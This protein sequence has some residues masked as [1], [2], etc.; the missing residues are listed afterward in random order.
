[1]RRVSGFRGMC[2]WLATVMLLV[3]AT[4]A[5]ARRW[6]VGEVVKQVIPNVRPQLLRLANR[7]G[8]AV[9]ITATCVAAAAV[10]LI[11]FAAPTDAVAADYLSSD[12]ELVKT[13][14]AN[15][16]F[17]KEPKQ[18]KALDAAD[19]GLSF[20]HW[21]AKGVFHDSGSNVGTLRL[22]TSA[23]VGSFSAY[24][25]SAFRWHPDTINGTEDLGVSTRT[26][27][28]GNTLLFNNGEG[29]MSYGYLNT[30]AFVG[31]T[32][33]NILNARA[34][35]LRWHE[36]VFQIAALGYEYNDLYLNDLSNPDERGDPVRSHGAA[37]YRAGIKYPITDLFTTSDALAVNVKLNS[38]M[39]LGDIGPVKLGET[40]QAELNDWAGDGADLNHLLHHSAGGSINV[41]LADGRI[42]LTFGGGIQH[43][44]DGDIK[45]AGMAEGD[46]DIVNTTVSVGGTVQ[47]SERIKLEAWF[48]RYDQATEA[49]LGGQSYEHNASGTWG[50]FAGVWTY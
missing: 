5:E 26:Y 48:D 39:H 12:A 21:G 18:L 37:I 41:S 35:L 31:G 43:T 42:N 8:G 25:T 29:K 15:A 36:G 6:N 50:R 16:I 38:A 14:G 9:K 49:Y 11:N 17:A 30:D 46:F 34:H 40:W 22:G 1:M 2:L 20:S 28:G 4:S 45:K 47:L 44:I 7:S 27:A 23:A 3:A 33:V 13:K 32:T 19:P 24:V 10:C